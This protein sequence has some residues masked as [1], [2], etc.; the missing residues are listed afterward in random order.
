[1]PVN[2]WASEEYLKV[3]GIIQSH[4]VIEVFKMN[5]VFR[6]IVSLKP[7]T[8]ACHPINRFHKPVEFTRESH[9]STLTCHQTSLTSSL[10]SFVGFHL[11]FKISNNSKAMSSLP[12]KRKKAPQPSGPENSNN[13]AKKPMKDPQTD[14]LRRRELQRAAERGRPAEEVYETKTSKNLS[15]NEV[16]LLAIHLNTGCLKPRVDAVQ[17]NRIVR[18]MNKADGTSDLWPVYEQRY[19]EL[20]SKYDGLLKRIGEKKPAASLARG[21]GDE[22]STVKGQGQFSSGNEGHGVTSVAKNQRDR[23]AVSGQQ[24]VAPSARDQQNAFSARDQSG[25]EFSGKRQ[26]EAASVAHDQGNIA[27][28]NVDHGGSAVLDKD[29]RDNYDDSSEGSDGGVPL[30]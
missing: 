16:L 21:Y 5:E 25:A 13:N 9:P 22:P 28:L 29:R 14:Y 3:L 20:K 8:F 6:I 2:D 17:R 1:M 15:T 7:A 10:N 4:V 19:F 18:I 11:I 23:S 26:A 24:N 27:S 12:L 30:D